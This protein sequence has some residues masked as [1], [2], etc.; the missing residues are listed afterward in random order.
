MSTDKQSMLYEAPAVLN[1]LGQP[2]QVSVEGDSVVARWKWM[3]AALFSPHEV[4]NEVRDYAFIVTLGDN[5]KWREQDKSTKKSGGVSF[6][7]GQLSFGGSKSSFSGKQM[8]KSVQFG[9][10]RNNQTGEF[11]IVGFRYDT[12]QV[13]SQVRAW[14]THHGWKKAGLLG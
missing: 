2:W 4:N 8:G 10:G 12:S 9:A 3:D 7:N 11:G 13:K 14:L 1:R 5:G 6:N